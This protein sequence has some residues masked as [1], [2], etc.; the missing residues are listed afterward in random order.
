[1]TQL[2]QAAEV[3]GKSQPLAAIHKA[4]VARRA[5]AGRTFRCYYHPNKEKGDTRMPQMREITA[6]LQFPEGPVAMNDGSVFPGS[7]GNGE[8]LQF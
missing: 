8:G 5:P 6:G 7:P 4:E 2:K 3:P 1:M